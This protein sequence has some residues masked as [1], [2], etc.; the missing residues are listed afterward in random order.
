MLPR[1]VYQFALKTTYIMCK[2]SVTCFS[3][4][5]VYIPCFL[6]AIP[7]FHNSQYVQEAVKDLLSIREAIRLVEV[8]A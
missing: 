8:F 6:S 5:I 4:L 7:Y 3:V 1:H 2:S